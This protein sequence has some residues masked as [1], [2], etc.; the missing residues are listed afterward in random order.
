M[1]K[2]IIFGSIVFLIIFF[3]T[4]FVLKNI[5]KT[6]ILLIGLDGADWKVINLL[7]KEGKLPNI[8]YLMENGSWGNLESFPPLISEVVWTTIFTGKTLDQHGIKDRL[9]ND[10]DTNELVPPTSNLVKVKRIWN[11]LS[12]YN[13]K[14]AS[15]GNR[16]TWP[17]EKIN[18]IIISDRIDIHQYQNKNYSYPTFVD[19]CTE[20]E[21]KNFSKLENSIFS[22]IEKE[23][24]DKELITLD[25]FAEE[26]DN[27]MANFTKY[28]L[29]KKEFDFLTVYLKGTDTLS[30]HFWHYLFPQD[31]EISKDEKYK[32]II[33]D[34]YIFCDKV[35]GD[36]IKAVD[37]DTILLIVSDH[38]FRSIPTIR[39]YY[40]FTGI[41]LLL[42]LC[43]L[44]KMIKNYKEVSIK[45]DLK[46]ILKAERSLNIYGDLN[47]EEFKE[48]RQEAKSILKNIKVKETGISIFDIIEDTKNGFIITID[49]SYIN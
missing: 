23:L 17:P 19:L 43:G 49:R 31:Y 20:E 27:F 18:G 15:I 38:G 39:Y 16:V 30:H 1:N 8:K 47:E 24:I 37:K 35:I 14:V 9:M 10:P 5:S 34:Y 3:L 6:K 11:I 25:R 12:E 7:L 41:D 2:R 36:L 42:E 32:D 28:I 13:K 33:K 40:L 48:I 45:C 22:H 46:E 21:F 29:K 26:R 4:S 44:N